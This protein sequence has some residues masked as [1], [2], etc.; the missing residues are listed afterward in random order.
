MWHHGSNAWRRAGPSVPSLALIEQR[1]TA[2]MLESRPTD[3]SLRGATSRVAG[4]RAREPSLAVPVRASRD[5]CGPYE[6][7]RVRGPG[8]RKPMLPGHVVDHRA[9]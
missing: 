3:E 5:C 9:A 1:W 7:E 2:T 4:R 8:L 6:S